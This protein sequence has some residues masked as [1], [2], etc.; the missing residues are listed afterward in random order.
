MKAFLILEKG[1]T[2]F[3]L[4]FFSG[5][6]YFMGSVP[7]NASQMSSE[8][9]P[10]LLGIQSGIQ[11]FS[12]VL[13]LAR[14]KSSIITATSGK[15]LWLL[16]AV[17]LA[18]FLWSDVPDYT[19]R[20]SLVLVGTSWFGLYLAARYSLK[21]QLHLLAWAMGLAAVLST[22]FALAFPS[23]GVMSS[24][25]VG[26]WRGIFAHKNPMGRSMVL[27][28]LVFLLLAI[29]SCRNRSLLMWASFGL[30]VGLIFLSTSKTALII[31]I[32]VLLLL[33]L[34]RTMRWKYTLA[35]P[36]W[37]VTICVS[38][39]VAMLLIDNLENLLGLM[40]R[41]LTFTGRTKLWSVVVDKISERPWL[42]YG[43]VAFWRGMEG[44]ESAK[45]SRLINWHADHSHNAFLDI[46]LNLGLLGLL[47]F[48]LSWLSTYL[49]A[50]TCLRS[51]KT[52]EWLW[53][54]IFLTFLLLSNLTESLLLDPTSIIWVLYVAL[55][56]SLSDNC[57]YH[58]LHN[59]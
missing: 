43:Y 46:S 30:S 18:S 21:E 39:G 47:L 51:T 54:P 40:G 28:A 1:F 20:R 16:L 56:L 6:L 14:W 59:S 52:A 17:A 19:L 27:S 35:V 41:D 5:C 32:A 24:I 9:S 15:L 26:A 2:I 34:Y 11:A 50:I 45:I 7:G 3:A 53:P 44:E 38:A 8:S 12:C 13:I 48:V 25:H 31:L 58:K 33:P 57:N 36:F 23:I 10:T 29:G 4:L 42:G 37:I 55:S 22:V 49:R